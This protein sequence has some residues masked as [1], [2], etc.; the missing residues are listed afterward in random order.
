MLFIP[1]CRKAGQTY[2]QKFIHSNPYMKPTLKWQLWCKPFQIDYMRGG[3]RGW[4]IFELGCIKLKEF[5][6]AGQA[7]SSYQYKGFVIRFA[8]WLPVDRAY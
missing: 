5:P 1:S 4:K 2:V 6:E 8:Y 3:D 7:I